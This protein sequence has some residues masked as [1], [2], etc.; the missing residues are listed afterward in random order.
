MPQPP[1][2]HFAESYNDADQYYLSG[3]LC[4]DPFA[5]L[6]L[7]RRKVVLGVSPMEEGRAIQETRGKA[8]VPLYRRKGKAF[9]QIL[10]SFIKDHGAGQVRVLPSFPVGLAQELKGEG[11]G[12]EIDGKTVSGRRRAK[13]P[14]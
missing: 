8:I 14:R 13:S 5:V 9:H 2:F 12:I 7:S 11:I 6:E 4:A 1:L 3:F 10:A